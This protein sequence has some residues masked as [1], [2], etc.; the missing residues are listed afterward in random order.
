MFG[1]LLYGCNVC[2]NIN[3]IALNPS[4]ILHP[5]F[6]C[7]QTPF[8]QMV[9]KVHTSKQPTAMYLNRISA[10]PMNILT[11][12]QWYFLNY[13][14]YIENVLRFCSYHGRISFNYPSCF[15]LMQLLR[16]DF[17]SLYVLQA[18][19]CDHMRFSVWR[20]DGADCEKECFSC[21]ILFPKIDCAS[22][23]V[24]LLLCTTSKK[25]K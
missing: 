19:W 8:A 25:I 5:N 20:R 9:F 10:M 3:K 24:P 2:Q 16:T 13:I 22:I 4:K 11:C 15:L 6:Y 23:I 18:E 1:P 7:I 21:D 12:R 17:E 14:T